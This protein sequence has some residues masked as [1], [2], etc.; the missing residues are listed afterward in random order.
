MINLQGAWRIQLRKAST[1]AA[2][3]LQLGCL[4]AAINLE[5]LMPVDMCDRPMI[6][7]ITKDTDG[8]GSMIDPERDGWMDLAVRS[9]LDSI[10]TALEM[11]E[12]DQRS[13]RKAQAYIIKKA[14]EEEGKEGDEEV[15]AASIGAEAT[16]A[17]VHVPT[18][19]D[20]AAAPAGG[21]SSAD[22]AFAT[23]AASA[24]ATVSDTASAGG[25]TLS[26]AVRAPAAAPVSGGVLGL[27]WI[28]ASVENASRRKANDMLRHYDR[29]RNTR[30]SGQRKQLTFQVKREREMER[31][32]DPAVVSQQ[33]E[34]KGKDSLAW[35][36]KQEKERAVMVA[37]QQQLLAKEQRQAAQAAQLQAQMQHE[38][39]AQQA[40]RL[41]QQQQQRGGA[42][43]DFV[44]ATTG[45]GSGGGGAAPASSVAATTTG[46]FRAN[47]NDEER[48]LFELAFQIYGP[49]E[50]EAI[51]KVAIC[52]QVDE[53]CI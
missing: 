32:Q 34:A 46:T 8:F 47:W 38:I 27:N 23:V 48:R 10:V 16:D 12:R 50:W 15:V 53:F 2:V 40:A 19:I 28:P 45:S 43:D 31:V 25:V 49:R 37:K 20:A 17:T 11:Q 41:A 52:I 14:T 6:R 7:N 29:V 4:F 35:Q 30:E 42:A 3:E 36:N 51:A 5:E 18:G 9:S 44:S 26:E 22:S 13:K 24:S 39:E 33:Q 21:S 1:V